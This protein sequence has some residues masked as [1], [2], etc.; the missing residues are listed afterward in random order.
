MITVCY[1]LLGCLVALNGCSLITLP[2]KGLVRTTNPATSKCGCIH[3]L[4]VC[5]PT[6]SI[7]N[8]GK[9]CHETGRLG[10]LRAANWQ[11]SVGSG[12]PVLGRLSKQWP[13]LSSIL[14]WTNPIADKH[15]LK[16][17]A[18]QTAMLPVPCRSTYSRL[19]GMGC[20]G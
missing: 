19:Y 10:F 1:V 9:R 11:M 16:V 2:S 14:Y 4:R 3:S 20:L 13:K 17:R 5:P 8:V 15:H 6:Q 12:T 18:Q 7:P